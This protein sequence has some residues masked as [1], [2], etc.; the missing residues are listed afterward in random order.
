MELG[1]KVAELVITRAKTDGS[2]AVFTGSIPTGPGFW[3]GTNPV[4]PLAGAWRTWVISSGREFRPPPPPAF[5]A[6][7]G[8]DIGL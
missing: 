5:D 2:D 4:T 8:M 7:T 3:R 6:R 1:S